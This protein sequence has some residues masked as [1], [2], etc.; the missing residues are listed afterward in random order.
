MS[1]GF[2]SVPDHANDHYVDTEEEKIDMQG[3]YIPKALLIRDKYCR[4]SRQAWVNA[5]DIIWYLITLNDNT[6]YASIVPWYCKIQLYS[7]YARERDMAFSK[8]S[9]V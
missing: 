3:I 5:T 7:T 8:I 4:V 2:G 9:Y 1:F 6:K